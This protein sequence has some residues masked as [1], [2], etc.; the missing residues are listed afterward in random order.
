VSSQYGRGGKGGGGILNQSKVKRGGPQRSNARP[1]TPDGQRRPPAPPR[2][3][4]PAHRRAPTPAHDGGARRQAT[5]LR[6]SGAVAPE[7]WGHLLS[8]GEP[9]PPPG[10]VALFAEAERADGQ[11]AQASGLRPP[12]VPPRPAP[13]PAPSP[14][15]PSLP[16]RTD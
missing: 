11:A 8:A 5:A 6:D 10:G 15:P 1:P 16:S 9:A 13:R 3:R 4:Q 2:A 14:A 7:E 12:A